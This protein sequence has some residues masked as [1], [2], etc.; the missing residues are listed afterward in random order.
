MRTREWLEISFG[1]KK[2]RRSAR[3]VFFTRLE[4]AD[5]STILIGLTYIPHSLHACLAL[6]I[7][8]DL[9]AAVL[10]RIKLHPLTIS[11]DYR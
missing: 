1:A 6:L 3:A 5:K 11:S 2:A 10:L 8:G 4:C 7:G 9:V